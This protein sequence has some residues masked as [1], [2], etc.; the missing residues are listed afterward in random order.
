MSQRNRRE[1]RE[2][3]SA[4]WSSNIDN[5]ENNPAARALAARLHRATG[6]EA[7]AEPA[8]YRLAQGLGLG[9]RDRD[10]CALILLATVL[11]EVRVNDRS[12]L[13]A[14][15]GEN[16]ALSRL[17][18]ERLIRSTPDELAAALR[19][20]LP[21]VERQCNVGTLGADLFFWNDKTRAT[22]CFEYFGAALAALP[23]TPQ[24]AHTEDT[25]A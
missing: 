21:M 4:W 13:A 18:F 25:Q 8:V 16:K 20:A 12:S 23:Q 2:I 17:R 3:I 10:A 7:L 24:T 6:V 5:R 14:R 1:I 15:L 11:A 9:K 19:R 22:W